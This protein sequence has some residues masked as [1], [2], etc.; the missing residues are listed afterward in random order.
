MYVGSDAL[1]L[2]PLD[3]PDPVSRGGRLGGADARAAPR[4]TPPTAREV[5]REIR[6]TAFSGA[7]IGQRQLPPLHAQGDPRAAGGAGRHAALVRQPAPITGSRCPICR[8]TSRPCRGSRWSPAAPRPTPAWSGATGS[9][10]SPACR[11]TSTSARSSATAARRWRPGSAA[12]FVSQSG[13]TM[14]TLEAMRCVKA[15]GL[16]T[17]ALVNVPGQHARARGR[18]PAAHARRPRDR[19][20]LDQGVHDPAR[21]ARLPRDRRRA[22]ARPPRA[23]SARPS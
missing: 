13:E 3:Q 10:S 19:R 4:S 1:A 18:L 21:D 7:L 22:R 2:A 14:D 12:L 11:S 17:I 9:S 15:Q 6:Q 16:K 8:S 23:P 5:A 20:R